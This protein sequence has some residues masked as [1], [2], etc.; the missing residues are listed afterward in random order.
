MLRN[1]SGNRK[2]LLESYERQPLGKILS[3]L[4]PYKKLLVACF[5]MGSMFNMI[6]LTVPWMLKIAIDRVLPAADYLL[7]SVLCVAMLIAY[8]CRCLLRYLLLMT[9]DYTGW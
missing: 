2:K 5:F 1:Q 6:V 3:L 9:F 7:F 4:A 8:L